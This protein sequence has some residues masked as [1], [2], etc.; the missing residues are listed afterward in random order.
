MPPKG[1]KRKAPTPSQEKQ[2]AKKK[3]AKR[4]RKG[5]AGPEDVT[6][7]AL[8]ESKVADVVMEQ[9][10]EQLRLATCGFYIP[11]LSQLQACHADYRIRPVRRTGVEVL[12]KLIGARGYRSV[13]KTIAHDLS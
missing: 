7:A 9:Y 5:Q 8:G 6:T 4:P 11:N 3:A 10:N 1:T 12:K 13:T 2:P